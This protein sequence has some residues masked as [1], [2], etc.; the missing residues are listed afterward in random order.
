[1]K[2]E[3]T[4]T[5]RGVQRGWIEVSGEKVIGKVCRKCCVM[6]P[7]TEYTPKSDMF[8][9]TINNCK[10]CMAKRQAEYS[11]AN[12]EIRRK[13]EKKWREN[14]PD[15]VKAMAQRS[16]KKNADGYRRRLQ[17]WRE[18]NPERNKE[19]QRRYN[20]NN[21]DKVRESKRKWR[22]ANP[23]AVRIQAANRRARL[24]ELPDRFSPEDA[25]LLLRMYG[26]CIIT[27][28]KEDIHWDHFIPIATGRGGTVIGNMVPLHKSINSR[29]SDKNP[30]DFFLDY[31]VPFEKLYDIIYILAFINDMTTAEYVDYVYECFAQKG[32]M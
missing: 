3:V 16:R 29:K 1:M 14:N 11:K 7:L 19:I 6:K 30:I 18:K 5:V 8:D 17:E 23:E 22:Q 4:S 12:P 31:G 25:E 32:V 10:A 21:P 2:Y 28:K 9:G 20:E 15:K 26:G 27:G 24:R 13:S